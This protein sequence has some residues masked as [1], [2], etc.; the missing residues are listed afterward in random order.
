MISDTLLVAIDEVMTDIA[1]KHL[2]SQGISYEKKVLPTIVDSAQGSPIYVRYL[3]EEIGAEVKTGAL[4]KLTN[5]RLKTAPKGMTDYVA[6]ILA[7]EGAGGVGGLR[8]PDRAVPD[9]DR[10]VGGAPSGDPVANT[11]V[12]SSS[13]MPSAMPRRRRISCTCCGYSR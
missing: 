3:A 4:T 11:S 5:S 13:R 8:G 7:R 12:S 9:V 6:G 2:E 1:K 10:G